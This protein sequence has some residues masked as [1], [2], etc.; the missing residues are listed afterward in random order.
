MKKI[1]FQIFALVILALLA[2][3]P[4]FYL[5]TRAQQSSVANPSVIPGS[6][7]QENGPRVSSI[8]YPIFTTD[9]A[10]LGSLISGQNNIM[11]YPPTDISNV[12]T[13]ESSNFLNVTSEAGS[14]EE[15]I[16]F[17]MYNSSDN[18]MNQ[19]AGVF[20]QFR[21][22]MAEMVNYTYIQDTVLNGIQG[23]AT[24]NIMYPPAWGAYSTNNVYRYNDSLAAANASLA[25]DPQIAWAA[26]ATQPSSSNSIACDGATGVWEYATALGSGTPNGTVFEPGLITRPDHPQWLTFATN[27]WQEAASIGLCINLRQV[28]GFGAVYPIVYAQYSTG[29]TMYTGGDS[30]TS[31]LDAITY[32]YYSYSRDGWSTPFDNTAHFYNSTLDPILTQMFST[33]NTTQA[34]ADS[35]YAEQVLTYQVPK[36]ELWWD[37]WITPSL[38]SYPGSGIYWSGYVDQPGFGTWS[39]GSNLWTALNAHM[40]NP[41]TGATIPGGTLGVTMHEAPDDFNPFQYTSVYDADIINQLY[42]QPVYAFPG[43]PTLTGLIP[44]MLTSMPNYTSHLNITTPHGY[45]MVNGLEETL[46]FMNN[47]TWWDNV[48]FTASDYNFTLWYSNVDGAS[49]NGTSIIGESEFDGGHCT[50]PC[51]GGYGAN[52]AAEYTADVP[53]LIDSVV[54]SPTTVNVYMNGSGIED[55]R[56][57]LTLDILPEHVWQNINSTTFNNDPIST[58]PFATINGGS[59]L[60]TGT[61]PFE[62]GSWVQNQYAIINRNPGY[63]RTDIKDWALS[64]SAGSSVPLNVNLTQEGS[65]IPTTA[66]VTA[67]I[68]Q[69]GQ[70]VGTPVTLAS[71]GTS[72]TGSLSTSGLQPGFY[73]I[74][75][76]GTYTSGGLFR[77][78]MQFWGLNL[79]TSMTTSQTTSSSSVTTSATA[80]PTTTATPPMT[81]S[82]T[83]TSTSSTPTSSTTTST[84]TSTTTSSTSYV[85]PAAIVVVVIIIIAGVA[86]GLSRRRPAATSSPPPPQT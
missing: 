7:A 30:F 33:T 85:V 25:A 55:Y 17:N 11:D 38:E 1:Q 53:D 69:N 44:W 84:A 56:L 41:T 10:A 52:V 34:E 12:E 36:I 6:Q 51:W 18:L 67:S 24:N 32:L 15:Y 21:Q 2:I 57:P 79:G 8:R 61:G 47:I 83:S 62:W 76:N 16:L 37:N 48:P 74:T 31:P 65:P 78:A 27:F 26:T 68:S 58:N 63:F 29:W 5:N 19:P 66:S 49:Y 59:W 60:T 81:S 42:D 22:A 39:T 43:D 9:S 13:A 46:T 80:I 82:S 40:V 50:A 4:V 28:T 77:T 35:V 64:G 20:L 54:T 71:S 23:I 14:S 45:T 86:I 75:V 72:W 73:E 70:S 3:S